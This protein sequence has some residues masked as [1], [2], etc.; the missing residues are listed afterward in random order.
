MILAVHE[1]EG[2][3]AARDRA[4]AFQQDVWANLVVTLSRCCT[5]IWRTEGISDGAARRTRHAVRFFERA[6]QS[7]QSELGQSGVNQRVAIFAVTMPLLA[8]PATIA[9]LIVFGHT[10]MEYG[11]VVCLTPG[12]TVFLVLLAI[13][14]LFRAA[15]RTFSLDRDYY[16]EAADGHDLRCDRV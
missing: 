16:H 3:L 4:A 9:T 12:L 14:P 6:A 13:T 15:H 10:A 1:V 11:K 2:L 5:L 7:H 8:G